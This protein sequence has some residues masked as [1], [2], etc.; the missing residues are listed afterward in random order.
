M[1][2]QDVILTLERYWGERGCVLL[3]PHDLMMGAG[4]F[5][6]ATTLRSLGPGAW[7]AAYV[8]PCRRPGDARYGDNPNRLGH[9]YQ[10]QVILK[11]SP[12]DVQEL[13]LGSLEAIGI[14]LRD[15]DVRFVEDDW[16]SPTLGAWGLGWEVWLNGMEATQF[17]YF[18]QVGG[19]PCAPVP[20]ELT[21]GL[22]RLTMS[23]Q[24]VSSIFDLT[25]V[26]GVTYR[27]VFHRNEVEQSRYNFEHS[28]PAA[29]FEEFNRNAAAAESLAELGL[30]LPAYDRAVM[31]SHSFNLLD[32]RGAISVA[33]RARYIRRVRDLAVRCVQV[34]HEQVAS[35]DHPV[36]PETVADLPPDDASPSGSRELFVEIL[37]EEL[38]ASMVEP[39]LG[40]LAEGLVG[41]L[42][43]IEHGAV[44]TFATPRRLAVAIADVADARPQQVRLVTGPPAE[45][46][47]DADGTPTRAAV[48]FARG[49]G[50]EPS[51]LKVV[52]GPRGRVVAV[53]VTEGGEATR[54]LVAEQLHG[55]VSALPFRKT[56]EWG[57]G[58]VR[59]GRPVHAVNAIYDGVRLQGRAM[60]LPITHT[61][62]GHRLADDRRFSFCDAA[63]WLRG[64]RD[65]AVEPDVALRRARIEAL[66]AEA[67]AQLGC[68][69][70]Q[71]EALLEEV[72]YLVEA[73]TLVIGAFDP[74]LLAL[75][76]RL[77]VQ[78][79][80][81]NQRYFP[82][83]RG[84]VLDE[85]FVIIS[86]NPWGDTEAI[87][88]GNAA[89]IH[90]RFDDARFFFAEDRKRSLEAHGEALA[91]MRWIRGLGTMAD[92][93]ARIAVL[94]RALAQRVG[95][96]PDHTQRA[97]QLSKSDLVTQMV[98]EFPSLQGHMGRLYAAAAG[99]PEAVALAIEEAWAPQ[100]AHDAVASSPEGIALALA[101]RLDTL[102]GCFGIGLVPKGGDPQGLRRAA[103]GVL[104]TL[105]EHGIRLDLRDL[106]QESVA[107]FHTAAAA[108]PDGYS[109][110][111]EAQGGGGVA[112]GAA[113][114]SDALVAFFL[115]RFRALVADDVTADIVDAVVAATEPDPVVMKHKVD[116]LAA[117]AGHGEFAEIMITFKRVLNITRGLE[118]PAPSA[119][120][121]THDAE[122][123]L[124]AATEAVE[125]EIAEAAQRLDYAHAL[126]RVLTLRLPVADL[127]DAVLVDD[128]DH[129]VERAARMGLLLRVSRSF[130]AVADF[131]RI[132]T[133]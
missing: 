128:P 1:N 28:D 88:A 100:H 77:L 133:R 106:V 67:T 105:I 27:D 50:V 59:W 101:D 80:K 53:E 72:L 60:A 91:K 4:T 117:L 124:L 107:A 102:V 55:V 98:G 96:D 57:T 34:W 9:Y 30:A 51:A 20:A 14:S 94:A 126:D 104:R 85:H 6:P 12:P 46:A 62:E 116:A 99:E 81:Q 21:Y 127:F 73:P 22:E 118:F 24:G 103:Q 19:L 29:L 86:N 52:E 63:S 69:P 17:T 40:A 15:N 93:Q 32:A 47:F 90:A 41:L 54:T 13:Y 112:S 66:L 114:V 109:A 131:S 61:T 2:F 7:R 56:M 35:K 84:G 121:L 129:P 125:G 122:R 42:E 31:T 64:L 23:L 120:E 75:P 82:V 119:Q 132:S 87:A 130:L 65:R 10:Y 115:A 18:Q 123:A 74:E 78:T 58:G 49:K 70:I 68:D 113:A 8:Q 3:Q 39:A 26:D 5:H 95:A 25:W 37:C 110:W 83:F 11:P 48:G 43:G 111:I 89:V 33:E 71:D 44:R 92:K 97:G 108:Q 45:R 79:M 36:I 16:E 76:P 38:P